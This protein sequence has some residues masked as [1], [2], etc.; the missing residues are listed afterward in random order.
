MNELD[1]DKELLSAFDQATFASEQRRTFLARLGRG[2]GT[3]LTDRLG[4]VWARIMLP[5]GMASKIIKAHQVTIAN[6]ALVDV[7]LDADGR[8]EAIKASTAA[9]AQEYWAR[10]GTGNTPQHG[11]THGVY[12][13]DPLEIESIQFL[14]LSVRPTLPSG[15]SVSVI[16]GLYHDTDGDLQSRSTTTVDLSSEIAALTGDEQRLVVIALNVDTGAISK[17]TGAIQ[18]FGDGPPYMPFTQAN[19]L[20]ITLTNSERPLHAVRIYAGQTN[21]VRSDVVPEL[22]L[23][24]WLTAGHKVYEF[25][26]NL[27]TF[28]D[29]ADLTKRFQFQ[30]SGITGGAT[31]IYTMPNRD[32][33]FVILSPGASS[34]N[35]I[36]PSG[37]FI[38][39]ILKGNASQTANLL[40]LQDSASAG[41]FGIS[42]SG[43]TRVGSSTVPT[44]DWLLINQNTAIT[45]G[46][47]N[48]IRSVFNSNPAASTSAALIAI[49]AQVG[50]STGNAQNHTDALSALSGSVSHGGTGTLTRAEGLRLVLSATSTGT[51]STAYGIRILAPINSGG[52]TISTA[53]GIEIGDHTVGGTNIALRTNAGLVIFNEGGNANSD[54]RIEG[55]TDTNLFFSDASADRVGI[56]ESAPDYKLDVNGAIGFTPGTSVTP[57]DNGDVVIEAT[58]NTTLTF[59]LKGSDGTVRTGTLT[60]T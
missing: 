50:I 4:W 55:D 23:R 21:I 7:R 51:I 1:L 14:P 34:D 31:R 46:S 16:G 27:V 56:G 38:P 17:T 15:T 32:T 37:D 20:A 58:N 10:H 22:D 48:G 47:D 30:A 45:S 29:N 42:P 9:G 36:Q 2:D 25:I 24:S 39:L 5:G 41:V 33:G 57:V 12:G 13:P 6:D 35:T 54:V 3:L 52:G 49:A 26:D 11:G 59:K 53:V 40:T 8:Y 28:K 19:A 60:L 44:I 43:R 18:D